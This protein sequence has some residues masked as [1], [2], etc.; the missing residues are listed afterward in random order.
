MKMR[1]HYRQSDG[2]EFSIDTTV[3]PESGGER[4][5]NRLLCDGTHSYY[6]WQPTTRT[7]RIEAITTVN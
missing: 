4:K 5:L 1:I 3:Y 7:V 2:H 6:T